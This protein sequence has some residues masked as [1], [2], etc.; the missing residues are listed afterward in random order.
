LQVPLDE[1]LDDLEGL[2]LAGS[3]EEQHV[4]QQPSSDAEM[5][6]H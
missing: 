2:N 4:Q 3:E 5:M 6:E 1:L